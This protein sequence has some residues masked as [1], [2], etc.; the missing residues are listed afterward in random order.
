M[1]TTIPRTRQHTCRDTLEAAK[2]MECGDSLREEPFWRLLVRSS[3]STVHARAAA[4]L[5]NALPG[6]RLLSPEQRQGFLA[7]VQRLVCELEGQP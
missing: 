2:R 1:A 3:D 5:D 7:R 6:L 4:K